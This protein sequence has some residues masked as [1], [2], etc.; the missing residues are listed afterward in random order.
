MTNLQCKLTH[1][2]LWYIS[3][4][5]NLLTEVFV[6]NNILKYI[7]WIGIDVYCIS[8]I[9]YTYHGK[10]HGSHRVYGKRLTYNCF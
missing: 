4:Y 7:N 10:A 5:A 3:R 1:Y 8:A 2:A 9:N 6:L